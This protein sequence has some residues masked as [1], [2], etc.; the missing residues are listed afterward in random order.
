MQI[1]VTELSA[2]EEAWLIP[3]ASYQIATP[4]GNEAAAKALFDVLQAAE[5]IDDKAKH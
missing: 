4:Y 1:L 2:E 5:D 3:G